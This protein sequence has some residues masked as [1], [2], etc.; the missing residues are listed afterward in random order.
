MRKVLVS[1]GRITIS[2]FVGMSMPKETR[3]ELAENNIQSVINLRDTRG[4]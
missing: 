3:N 4:V 2:S 1:R